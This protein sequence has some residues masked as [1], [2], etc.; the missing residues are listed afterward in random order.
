ME[1]FKQ[2]E[3]TIKGRGNIIYPHHNAI[4]DFEIEYSPF[5][6]C[7][8]TP[9]INLAELFSINTGE[10][11]GLIYGTE[12]KIICN[13][14]SLMRFYKNQLIFAI[15]DNLII[16]ECKDSNLLKVKLFGLSAKIKPF[17]IHDF[18]IEFNVVSNFDE[19]NKFCLKYGDIIETSELI[20]KR[21][22]NRILDKNLSLQI[23]RDICLLLSFILAK[24]VTF[25]RC[26]FYGN[27]K[28]QEIINIRL[29][30]N[31]QGQRF[32]LAKNIEEIITA[33]YSS[34]SRM[35]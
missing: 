25:N 5:Q 6:I 22:D 28:S 18:N 14:I 35:I 11:E 23:S 13:K 8:K 24:N 12:T 27:E 16:G 3:F 17:K 7:L 34:I 1:I 4:T 33:F 26:E 30:S 32:V 9:K 2:N 31:N 19:I 21:T 15:H 10:F 29:L 20:V